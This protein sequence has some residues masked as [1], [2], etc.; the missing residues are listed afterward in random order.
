MH[1][2]TKMYANDSSFWLTDRA[3]EQWTPHL[4]YNYSL[5]FNKTHVIFP[6]SP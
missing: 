1:A 4:L 2:A 5:T 6:T 3:V